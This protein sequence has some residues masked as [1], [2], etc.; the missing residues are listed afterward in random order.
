MEDAM[1][2]MDKDS[3]GNVI[4]IK[5]YQ[6]DINDDIF[7]HPSQHACDMKDAIFIL[8]YS[9]TQ[10]NTFKALKKPELICNYR[11][12]WLSHSQVK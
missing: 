11:L 3:D 8:W 1:K 10:I 7:L 9:D 5:S 12:R 6:C 4:T 2:L